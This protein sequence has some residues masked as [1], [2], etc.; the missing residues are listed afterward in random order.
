MRTITLFENSVD[1][2]AGWHELTI[3]TAK[4]GKSNDTPVLDITFEGYPDNF[5]MRT[6]A[7]H[8]EK[9]NEEWRIARLFRFA[10]AGITE[11]LEEDGK[12]RIA[13]NDDADQLV[14]KKLN[15]LFYKEPVKIDGEERQYSRAYSTP[16]P[17]VFTNQ[18]ESYDED[19]VGRFKVKAEEQFANYGKGTL[20]TN[21]TVV[22]SEKE[23]VT[24]D[25]E[26][27][28]F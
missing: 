4:Y 27:L 1:Y 20:S 26:D 15:V 12:K 8:N 28:P 2:T 24:A 22:S 3:A 16:A 19:A 5:N 25:D 14:G 10:N 18:A 13:L 11:V 6:W 9:T 17:T 7:K 21:G 23:L